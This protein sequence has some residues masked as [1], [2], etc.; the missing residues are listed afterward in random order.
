ML[1][2]CANMVRI[3]SSKTKALHK[4]V[5]DWQWH[6]L[7]TAA[8]LSAVAD[9]TAVMQYMIPHLII[10]G[11]HCTQSA[12]GDTF[13]DTFWDPKL[14]TP[15]CSLLPDRLD[16]VKAG[17]RVWRGR[18]NNECHDSRQRDTARTSAEQ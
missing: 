17:C 16:N 1:F 4:S 2:F 15:V 6:K 3:S 8:F 13:W 11:V 7:R 5:Q 18:D 10:A 14:V 9:G 12:C